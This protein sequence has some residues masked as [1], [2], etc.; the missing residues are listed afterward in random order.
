MLFDLQ[1]GGQE[2]DWGLVPIYFDSPFLTPP[3]VMMTAQS[4]S[5]QRDTE[6][7]AFHGIANHVDQ[8]GFTMAVRSADPDFGSMTMNWIALGR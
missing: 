2:S 1:A 3:I 5:A 4:R 7:R 6:L 8:Y